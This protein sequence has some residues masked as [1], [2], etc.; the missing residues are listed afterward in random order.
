MLQVKLMMK[1]LN[2]FSNIESTINWI[3]SSSALSMSCLTK[4]AKP[5]A[6]LGR[7]NIWAADQGRYWVLIPAK[8]HPLALVSSPAFQCLSI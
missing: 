8:C 4:T 5:S 6:L 1:K 2:V 7:Q 3:L